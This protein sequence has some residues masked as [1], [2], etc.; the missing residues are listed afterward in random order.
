VKQADLNG[1]GII[2][3]KDLAEVASKILM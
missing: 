3:I 2:D 1:D